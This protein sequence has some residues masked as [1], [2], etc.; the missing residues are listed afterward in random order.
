MLCAPAYSCKHVRLSCVF[1]NKLTY[2]LTMLERIAMVQS[3][4]NDRLP[5]PQ[6]AFMV[7]FQGHKVK[8]SQILR[9]HYFD[10]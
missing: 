6:F 8:F 10:L 4:R 2:L 3:V 9:F 5:T 7:K 1:Y